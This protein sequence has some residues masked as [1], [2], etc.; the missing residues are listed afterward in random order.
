MALLNIITS[1]P[2]GE[3]AFLI[4]TTLDSA[5]FKTLVPKRKH[6]H[7]GTQQYSY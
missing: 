2:L 1:D 4:P 5:D 6:Y 7:Q 3:F